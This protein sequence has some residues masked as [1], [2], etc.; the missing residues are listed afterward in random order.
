VSKDG[1]MQENKFVIQYV[2]TLKMIADRLTKALEGKPFLTFAS[3][4]LGIAME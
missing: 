3:N 4:M 1:I 2:H